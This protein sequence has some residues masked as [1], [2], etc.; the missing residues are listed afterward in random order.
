MSAAAASA[1]TTIPLESTARAPVPQAARARAPLL[2]ADGA[3]RRGR[4]PLLQRRLLQVLLG[5]G[6][7]SEPV[8]AR[9]HLARHLGV[10]A[11]VGLEQR[12]HLEGR[13]PGGAEDDPRPPAE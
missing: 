4:G 8:P 12:A 7:W 1:P 13:D 10:T 6:P 5:I 11:L 9:E 3:A 2:E